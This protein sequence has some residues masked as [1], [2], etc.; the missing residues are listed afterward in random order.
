MNG[1][2][3]AGNGDRDREKGT[4]RT[5]RNGQLGGAG[6]ES[7]HFSTGQLPRDPRA[8]ARSTAIRPYTTPT[9]LRRRSG[10]ASTS[11]PT[12][13]APSPSTA[14]TGSSASY[15]SADRVVAVRVARG[16]HLP[17]ERPGAERRGP[18]GGGRVRVRGRAEASHGRVP[19]RAGMQPAPSVHAT[20]KGVPRRDGSDARGARG[21]GAKGRI[22]MAR[23][24]L[25]PLR[26]KLQPLL[27]G[28][29]PRAHPRGADA[30]VHQQG[31]EGVVLLD[32]GYRALVRGEVR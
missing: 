29:G 28:L 9:T 32:R 22:A 4:R 7:K 19:V 2:D 20:A 16:S 8:G 14:S 17:H 15:P 3:R 25:Q 24:R 27:R 12:S 10:S 21:V 18:V 6:D 26:E 11:S 30:A 1:G 23:A 31:R 13:S 5:T